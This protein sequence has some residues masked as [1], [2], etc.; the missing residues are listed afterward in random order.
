MCGRGQRDAA[1]PR[2]AIRMKRGSIVLA[3]VLF[4]VAAIAATAG[5]GAASTQAGVKTQAISCK[6]TMK[7][8]MVTPLTGGAGFLGTEQL[9]WAKYAVKTVAPRLGLK[10]KLVTGDTPVE[11]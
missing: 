11:Q 9:S 2:R 5:T 3:L 6:S 1:R 4:V 8:A 7:L 10:I